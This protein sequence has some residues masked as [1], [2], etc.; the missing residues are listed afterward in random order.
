MTLPPDRFLRRLKEKI[1]IA[2]GAMGTMIQ[3][4][5]PSPDDFGGLD[6]CNEYLICTRPEIIKNIY[7]AYLDAGA[8]VIET[9]TF[10]SSKLVLAEYDVGERAHEISKL[11]AQAARVLADEFASKAWPRFV[12]GS[13]GPGTKLPTLGHITF[14]EMFESYLPQMIGLIEG[15]IDFFQIETCQDLLQV[16]CA[17]AAAVEA[18]RRCNKRIPIS[19]TVTIETTGTMLVGSEVAAA[20]VV[21][22]SLPVDMIGF[23]CATGPDMMQENVR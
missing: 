9:N 23:N 21:L 7:S 2:D 3:A 17:V 15:G 13:V 1:I 8:D 22:E 5:N 11:N 20:L 4:A 10:G 12:A 19:V 18:M 16:K 6:G 14:D